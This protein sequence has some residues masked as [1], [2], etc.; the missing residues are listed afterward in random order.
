MTDESPGLVR[1]GTA[2]VRAADLTG[3]TECGGAVLVGQ[4]REAVTYSWPSLNTLRRSHVWVQVPNAMRQ[5]CL[6]RVAHHEAA[7]VVTMSEFGLQCP[8]AV[9]TATGGSASW[10]T[11]L[12]DTPDQPAPDPR[13]AELSATAAAVYA[14]GSMAELLYL[15]IPWTGPLHYPHQ[16]DYQMSERMLKPSF[17]A[18]S[19]AGHAFAQRAALSILQSR[20]GEVQAIAAVLIERGEWVPV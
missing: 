15:G 1:R 17:G 5:P 2:L 18:H 14:S 8:K 12:P 11:E 6:T 16:P 7:H 4:R 13:A 20:W 9:A 10:P 3:T 19:S